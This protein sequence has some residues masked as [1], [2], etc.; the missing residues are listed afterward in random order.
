[1]QGNYLIYLINLLQKFGITIGIPQKEKL[2]EGNLPM[3]KNLIR[4][5]IKFEKS[6][7][8]ETFDK[9]LRVKKRN[10]ALPEVEDVSAAAGNVSVNPSFVGTSFLR[11]AHDEDLPPK[12]KKKKR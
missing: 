8:S 7:G 6:G 5:I 3:I 10:P 9:V 4:L 2:I 11:A 12:Q 1:M